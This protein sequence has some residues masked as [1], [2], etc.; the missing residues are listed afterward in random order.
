MICSIVK[1]S[2]SSATPKNGPIE[3]EAR[4]AILDL[5]CTELENDSCLLTMKTGMADLGFI[6]PLELLQHGFNIE[7]DELMKLIL[8]R[9]NLCRLEN[10]ACIDPFE[11][12]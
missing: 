12:L 8:H 6:K 10:D 1:N 2:P 5:T 9:K 3:I 7:G 11:I 4:K